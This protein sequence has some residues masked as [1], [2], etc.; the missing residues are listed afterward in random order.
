MRLIKGVQNFSGTTVCKRST[1]GFGRLLIACFFLTGIHVQTLQGNFCSPQSLGLPRI[2]LCSSGIGT[3][4][5]ATWSHSPA[6]QSEGQ[7]DGRWVVFALLERLTH[8]F[9]C[10]TFSCLSHILLVPFLSAA[11]SLYRV[12]SKKLP[13]F[14]QLLYT[15]GGSQSRNK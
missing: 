15:R 12:C 7:S 1:K 10:V 9:A 4:A 8:P 5:L 14:C 13:V 2:H 11:N 6:L 3:H